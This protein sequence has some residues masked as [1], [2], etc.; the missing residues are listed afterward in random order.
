MLQNLAGCVCVY[1]LEQ[2]YHLYCVAGYISD[3]FFCESVS[4]SDGVE[5][6]GCSCVMK[7]CINI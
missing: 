7:V 4:S 5:I 1:I 3:M 2:E 6:T